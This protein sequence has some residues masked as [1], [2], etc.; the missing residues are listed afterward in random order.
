MVDSGGAA[1]ALLV[2]EVVEDVLVAAGGA[3]VGVAGADVGG[4]DGAMV[5]PGVEPGVEADTNPSR[6][7][8]SSAIGPVA[9]SLHAPS[10]INRTARPAGVHERCLRFTTTIL[11]YCVPVW[12]TGAAA[13]RH[14]PCRSSLRGTVVGDPK[15]VEH[16]WG[17]DTGLVDVLE[18][19]HVLVSTEGP[20]LFQRG[21]VVIDV[22][23]GSGVCPAA[24][25]QLDQR[26]Y[27]IGGR[28]V[29]RREAVHPPL[30]NVGSC[31]QQQLHHRR[32]IGTVRRQR[33]N[34]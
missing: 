12:K 29:Q 4:G 24:Q 18:D 7:V 26:G 6:P 20:G 5:E 8:E 1:V 17:P 33:S 25:Q 34:Q 23:S 9:T 14:Q 13:R 27:V 21:G 31:I 19:R 3:V 28:I 32:D 10:T 30:L 22:G 11:P 15:P 2:G 16:S